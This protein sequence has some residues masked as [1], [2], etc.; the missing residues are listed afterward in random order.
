MWWFLSAWL[1]FAFLGFSWEAGS[2]YLATL[3][4]SEPGSAPLVVQAE[5]WLP[6]GVGLALHCVLLLPTGPQGH[7]SFCNKVTVEPVAGLLD[8]DSAAIPHWNQ[9]LLWKVELEGFLPLWAS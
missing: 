7:L 1:L 3:V 8:L 2:W 4:G 6:L 5:P 9:G